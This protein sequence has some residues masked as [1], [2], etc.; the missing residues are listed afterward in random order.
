[1]KLTQ[2]VMA[3]AVAGAMVSG[4]HAQSV[5]NGSFESVSNL[6]SADWTKYDDAYRWSNVSALSVSNWTVGTGTGNLHLVYN[7]AVGCT[8]SGT[9]CTSSYNSYDAQAGNVFV[10]LTGGT[11]AGGS[12]YNRSISQSVSGLT[13]GQTYMIEFYTLNDPTWNTSPVS[14]S[15]GF[16]GSAQTVSLASATV[17]TPWVHQT[18]FFTPTTTASTLSFQVTTA[19]GNIQ[20]VGLDNVSVSAV[21]E[22][23]SYALFLSGL[24][25]LAAAAKRR[26][27]A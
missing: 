23:E 14:L 5:A 24:A 18:L 7:D 17:G 9:T 4:V 22:P 15:V 2:T 1:M 12:G 25:V 11:N 27:R 6:T 16:A 13:V 10:D 26:R 21:P 19:S 20:L 3:L 8:V